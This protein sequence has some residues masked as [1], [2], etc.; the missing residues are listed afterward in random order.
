VFS[1]LLYTDNQLEAAEG[2][3]SKAINLLSNKGD[4]FLVCQYHHILGNIYFSKGKVEAAID[5][6]RIAL[7]IASSFN[8]HNQLFWSHYSL[9]QLFYSQSRFNDVHPHIGYAKSHVVN[10]TYNL[11]CVIEL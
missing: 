7:R 5:H 4:Q 11:G 10:N 1:Q 2:A 3:A 8:W 6:L 9:A